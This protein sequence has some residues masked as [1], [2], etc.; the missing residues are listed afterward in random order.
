MAALAAYP[1][2]SCSGSKVEVPH[3]WGVFEH[4]YCAGNDDTLDFLTKVFE[5]ALEMFGDYVSHVH[6]GGDEC[7]K[8]QWR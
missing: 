5:E 2:Y 3:T 7:P 4:V 6:I 8:S 1:Q